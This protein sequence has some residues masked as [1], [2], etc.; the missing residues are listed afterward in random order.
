MY[1]GKDSASPDVSTLLKQVMHFA[2]YTN[3]RQILY[4]LSSYPAYL[5]HLRRASLAIYTFMRNDGWKNHAWSSSRRCQGRRVLFPK[6]LPRE[7]FQETVS[8]R[9]ESAH[10]SVPPS[11]FGLKTCRSLSHV[12][13]SQLPN[14]CLFE[15]RG[16]WLSHSKHFLRQVKLSRRYWL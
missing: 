10:M 6:V 12:L 8:H 4:I 5:S 11:V 13:A 3:L 1:I 14:S 16:G 2:Q 15:F 9:V 7:Y